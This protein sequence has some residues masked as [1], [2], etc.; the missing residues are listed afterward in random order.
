ME[1]TIL[2]S[3]DALIRLEEQKKIL[4]GGLPLGDRAFVFIVEAASNEE[5]DR[6]L[7]TIPM[8]GALKWSVTPLQSFAG[9]AGQEREIVEQIKKSLH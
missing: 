8:W 2:P 7:R 4:A 9:R 6:M 3:F 5:V 1:R